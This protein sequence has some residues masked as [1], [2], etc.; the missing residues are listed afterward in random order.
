MDWETCQI[1]EQISHDLISLEE[2]PFDGHMIWEEIDE[3]LVLIQARSFMTR[4]LE[5]NGK[6]FEAEG[7]AKLVEWNVPSGERTTIARD[8]LHWPGK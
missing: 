5:I 8:L 4:N 7:K 2:Q 1:L 3:K 6:E